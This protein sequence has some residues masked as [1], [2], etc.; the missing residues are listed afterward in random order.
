MIEH[1]IAPVEESKPA[2]IPGVKLGDWL[3]QG[4]RV[5]VFMPPQWAAV[6]TSPALIAALVIAGVLVVVAVQRMLITGPATFEWQAIAGDWLGTLLIAWACLLLRPER[7]DTTDI[8]DAGATPSAAMFF[9][10]I[11]AQSLVLLL[12]SGSLLV[13]LVRS[14]KYTVTAI[15]LVGLWIVYLVPMV[16]TALA[17]LAMIYRAGSGSR[18]TLPVV[19][20]VLLVAA[21][22]PLA[23][24]PSEFWHAAETTQAG[25]VHKEFQLTQ[26]AM[27]SQPALLARRLNDLQAQRPGVVD[28]YALTFAPYASEDVFRRESDMVAGVMAQ[29]FDAKGRTLQLVNHA[30]T[31]AQWPWATPLNFKR[32]IQRFASVMDRDEDILFIHLTSHGARDGEL[33][34]QFLPMTLDTLK[35]GD[36]KHWLDQSGIKYRVISISACFSG[37]WIATLANENTLVMTASDAEHTSY[38]CGRKSALTFFGRA[39]Y[40]EQLRSQ[41]WSFEEAHAAARRIIKQREVEAGKSDGY[42]NPQIA[43]GTAIRQQLTL[44]QMRVQARQIPSP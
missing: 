33:A 25:P 39:M 38:G 7:T 4:A 36:L 32:A 5:A 43:V 11:L 18:P 34:A 16:W 37:S 20:V 29:R 15:G 35:P 40:D 23:V 42:S 31:T 24:P 10:M 44:L 21:A 26:Q 1:D 8:D 27:E 41:T 17:Q 12:V 30:D 3:R 9:T 6:R 19:A 14:G 22:I 2:S 13:T 28:L